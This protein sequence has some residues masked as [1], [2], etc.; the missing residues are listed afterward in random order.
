MALRAARADLRRQLPGDARA[1]SSMP[2]IRTRATTSST[3]VLS[4]RVE[5]LYVAARL[6]PPVAAPERPRQ[7]AAGGLEHAGRP[8]R[9]RGSTRG[10]TDVEA[11]LDLRGAILKTNVDYDWELRRRASACTTGSYRTLGLIGGAIAA[12]IWASTGR[13]TAATRPACRGEGG[14]RVRAAE[15]RAI[16]LFLAV[17]RRDRPVSARVRHRQPG[18]AWACGC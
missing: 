15:G 18:P 13:A 5:G 17:E 9:A 1:R 11:R 12:R 3:G 14:L 4:T 7:A 6:P 16:E 2:S 8:R 10:G